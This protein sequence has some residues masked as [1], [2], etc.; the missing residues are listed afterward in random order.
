[1]RRSLVLFALVISCRSP[2]GTDAGIASPPSASSATD[3]AR[4]V[5]QELAEVPRD[6]REALLASA[7]SA[8]LG[9]KHVLA[10]VIDDSVSKEAFRRFM[11]ELDTGKL[12]LLES[13]VQIA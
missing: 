1:M 7:A 13:D 4:P 10:R 5:D 12:I 6:P 2:H 3:A 8:L 9:T 11:D